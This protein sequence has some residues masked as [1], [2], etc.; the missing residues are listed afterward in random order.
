MPD[1]RQAMY[2][3]VSKLCAAKR[4]GLAA[5]IKQSDNRRA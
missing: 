1:G 2:G 3:K 5:A 4:S